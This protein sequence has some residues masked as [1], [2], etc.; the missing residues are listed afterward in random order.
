METVERRKILICGLLICAAAAWPVLGDWFPGDG[1]K[2]HHPQ[3][4]DPEGWDVC[5]WG[6][7]I[8][9][10]FKCSE[11]GHVT[12]LHFWIS[13]KDDVIG[14]IPEWLISIHENVINSNG[15]AWPGKELWRFKAGH[16]TIREEAPSLQG[17]L[18]PCYA[19]N[20]DPALQE[21][22]V[23]PENHTRY[24]QVNIT[25][26]REPF[27]QT[28]GEVYW[29][30]VRAVLPIYD[31]Y[32]YPVIRSA[33][34]WKTSLDADRWG[35]AAL[36]RPFLQYQQKQYGWSD[37]NPDGSGN[38]G[39]EYA[40]KPVTSPDAGQVRLHDM[41]FVVTGKPA[42][43]E[44]FDFG[45][46][47]ETRCDD[48]TI[49]CNRYPTTLSRD[50]AR[51][52]INPA[53]Y[54]GDPAGGSIHIDAEPDGQ[55][56]AQ[57]DGDDLADA[58]DEDGVIFTSPIVGGQAADVDVLASIEGLLD[59]WVDFNVDGDWDDLG[60]R[61]FLAEPLGP[62]INHLS[63]HVPPTGNVQPRK[64]YAR[65]RFSTA[66]HLR[67]HGPARDG[68]VEDY[69]VEI[70]P[71]QEPKLDFGDAPDGDLVPSGY[72]TILLNN[73]ARHV[74]VPEVRLGR[75]IDG[76]PDGRPTNGA[77]GDDLAGIDDEDGV[78][79][80]RP[81]VPGG[82]T[83][84]K[85][86]ASIDGFL[87]A[88]IDFDA[89]GDWAGP[90]DQVFADE[91]LAAG[92]N[93]LQ[94]NVPVAA[95][96]N[97]AT[98]ARFRFTSY[99]NTSGA[100]PGYAGLAEDGEVEDYI[101]KIAEPHP[102]L[103]FGDAPE[104]QCL[105][106]PCSH[107]P[108]T[109]ANDGARHVIDP[110]VY[111]GD[112]L[113]DSIHIDAEADGQPTV[114]ADG[115]DL[116]GADDEDGVIF[117]TPIVPGFEAEVDVLASTR[118]LLDAWVDFNA[119]G[120]WDDYGERIFAGTGLAMGVNHLAFKVPPYPYA[121]P[122][123]AR[124]Y[125]RF[126]FSTQ[127]H[128]HYRGPARDGEVEDYLVK[129]EE[130]ERAADLGDAPDST[131]SF[132]LPM[133]AY[134]SS[135]MLPVTV[136]AHFP[137]VY[138]AGSPPFG[139][140]HWQPLAV[141]CLGT[142]VSLEREADSG[143]D[144]DGDNNLD[145]QNDAADLDGADD[146]VKLPLVLPHCRKTRFDYL[147]KV[148]RPVHHLYVNVWL[149]FNR[150]GDWDDV[151]ECGQIQPHSSSVEVYRPRLA[152]EWA[153]RNQVLANLPEGIHSIKTPPFVSWHPRPYPSQDRVDP[154]WM[155]ITLSERPFRPVR[156]IEGVA[157]VPDEVGEISPDFD[158]RGYAGSGPKDGYR[159]GET[160]DYYFIPITRRVE[161]A[162]LD[163]DE[164]VNLVDLAIFADQYLA[165]SQ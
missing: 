101:V 76:E 26:I 63:F 37:L 54:L 109:L 73:G 69:M 142:D 152:R 90:D 35:S 84:V 141:A 126:R 77:N 23:I 16:I 1:H 138:A 15:T 129:I 107:Y 61:I 159:L 29:L 149:D 119:D 154:I 113:T 123:N 155:R 6:Q 14:Y 57:A 17:W 65:F 160:E 60:E 139:P 52:L 50:G 91:P 39:P 100:V 143:Y 79:I 122:T 44:D 5:L 120:D 82:V 148:A 104:L 140:I 49:R 117:T 36:W 156:T 86:I 121:V 8:A 30:I 118:G 31:A 88:W 133:T 128:L 11:T 55:P 161:W 71:P 27:L 34:G 124:T 135:G 153:V 115:D 89:D 165:G 150:D 96:V 130:P 24:L 112:P 2:M 18:C 42:P 146:G 32:D 12:D 98:Y 3:L 21:Q 103:D 164:V 87:N 59:A 106:P 68:E 125:A 58:D 158:F 137:T 147:V 92:V 53:V 110:A 33:V 51:H 38:A 13:W 145:P 97:K 108:T 43:V 163:S 46:A 22:T 70:L 7:A 20:T 75:Y 127:G 144:E 45:D 78:F 48:W 99:P 81:L 41:A 56:T 85:V 136:P 67:Y 74:I 95:A 40:W 10:D 116:N 66:G 25:D 72:P 94:V 105:V 80:D 157:H 4:P 134:P 19:L 114:G 111:L 83:E 132:N 9:D 62:G 47:P 162:D 151:M 28:A 64:T 131:N 93:Y 102:P